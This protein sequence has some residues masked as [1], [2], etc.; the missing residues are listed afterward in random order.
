MKDKKRL[1]KE[2]KAIFKKYPYNRIYFKYNRLFV[3][4]RIGKD[5]KLIDI[6]YF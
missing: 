2:I 1:Y 6:Y 5:E 4:K 3:F